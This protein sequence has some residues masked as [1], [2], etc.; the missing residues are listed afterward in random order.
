MIRTTHKVNITTRGKGVCISGTFISMECLQAHLL[1]CI[2][3]PTV[4][5]SLCPDA[6][7][8]QLL[9]L[10]SLVVFVIT[11]MRWQAHVVSL[12]FCVKWLTGVALVLGCRL[13]FGLWLIPPG[14]WRSDP[15]IISLVS[16]F[17]FCK[18]LWFPQFLFLQY[19]GNCWFD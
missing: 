6:V 17:F 16:D 10:Q 19:D 18:D 4:G 11:I 13:S 8:F 1:K 2:C 7:I 9:Y 5:G 3:S 14:L 15:H 12:I